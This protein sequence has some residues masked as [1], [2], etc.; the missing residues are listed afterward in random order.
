MTPLCD[1]LK[2]YAAGNPARF[3]MPGHKGGPLPLPELSGAARLDAPGS[4]S[5][6]GK[7]GGR[8]AMRVDLPRRYR[9][10]YSPG[11]IVCTIPQNA[12]PVKGA[13]RPG[14]KFLRRVHKPARAA[15]N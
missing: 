4:H 13:Q 15:A 9:R 14:G 6:T 2:N 11:E 1:V 5:F 3:H 8:A 12:R 10:N 7:P